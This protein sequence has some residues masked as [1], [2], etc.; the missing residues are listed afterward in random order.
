MD[1][2]TETVEDYIKKVWTLSHYG[3]EEGLVPLGD[4]AKELNLSPG[5]VTTMVKRFAEAG[6]LLYIPRKGCRLT[7]SGKKKAVSVLKK[8]RLVEY[9]LVETLGMK[10]DEVHREAEILEH[11]FS[12][13]VIEKLDAFL[14]YPPLDPHGK[15]I[16]RS[17]D[18][19]GES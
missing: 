4:L 13:K 18:E 15:R 8:H 5:T 16:L 10:G 6:W 3:S 1:N 9:F 17:L 19:L 7:D 14:G 11:G 2:L 12:E